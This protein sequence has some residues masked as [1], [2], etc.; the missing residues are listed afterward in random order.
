VI[1]ELTEGLLPCRRTRRHASM[2]RSRHWVSATGRCVTRVILT[3]VGSPRRP[4]RPA[5]QYRNVR[6]RLVGE[7][8]W[9]R[10]KRSTPTFLPS[11][12]GK[13][14]IFWVARQ[15]HTDITLAPV[16]NA[17]LVFTAPRAGERAVDI[18]CVCGAPTL[19]FA[20]AAGPSG[21]VTGLDISG[22]M[23]A[24]GERRA[25]AA[26]IANVGWRQVDPATAA[27]DE[28]D[29][30]ISTFGVILRRPGG[31]VHQYAPRRRSRR[32]HGARVLA[33]ENP[34]MEVPMTADRPSIHF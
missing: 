29:L 27:M 33:A 34:W 18:G 19:E 11:G 32:T 20:R 12:T 1:F 4:L 17:L 9:L 30:L 28:H 26:G 24:E 25:S 22:P 2:T 8:G 23:L 5:R 16:T 21:R 31:D 13:A 15:E 7:L 3:E 14:A 10:P 6:T